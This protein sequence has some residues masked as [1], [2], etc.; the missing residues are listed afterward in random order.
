MDNQMFPLTKKLAARLN[1]PVVVFDIEHT[2]GRKETRGITEFAAYV[3]LP[4]G[5]LQAYTSLVKPARYV[6]FNPAVTRITGITPR[7]V[8]GAPAWPKVAQ[9][10]VLPYQD[11]L[12]VGYNS[13]SSDMPIVVEEC[14]RHGLTLPL[15]AR[16]L[17]LIRVTPVKGPLSSQIDQLVPGLDTGGAHRAAKD[18]L[19]TLW[20]L[21]AL[22]PSLPP[23][24]LDAAMA[25]G[26][27]VVRVEQP[28]ALRF[29]DL[30]EPVVEWRS[31]PP[32]VPASVAVGQFVG[33][34]VG[35]FL[36][37]FR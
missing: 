22:L 29:A 7:T 9:E 11:A 27:K 36:S 20:L 2:G 14:S 6:E 8:A 10:A 3:M 32:E 30:V 1:R 21:E 23:E 34:A 28:D 35:G 26:S 15:P 24:L 5:K 18:A 13:R 12:W 33:R 31:A 16:H 17:D 37:A 25:P 4:E 19:M